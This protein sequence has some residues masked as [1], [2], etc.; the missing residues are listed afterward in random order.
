MVPVAPAHNLAATAPCTI[1]T[2]RRTVRHLAPRAR[3]YA[4][5]AAASTPT[6]LATL[7]LVQP[8]SPSHFCIAA[9]RRPSKLA[10]H[11]FRASIK[12]HRINISIHIIFRNSPSC[13]SSFR[14]CIN[15]TGLCCADFLPVSFFSRCRRQIQSSD[16]TAN[17]DTDR[18]RPDQTRFRLEITLKATQ[19]AAGISG[20]HH[21]SRG[22]NPPLRIRPGY[23]RVVL[24]G[25]AQPSP[26]RTHRLLQLACCGPPLL[27]S[28]SRA[29]RE[30]QRA[31]DNGPEAQSQ[32]ARPSAPPFSVVICANF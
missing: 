20:Y 15:P 2:T 31:S 6:R 27:L 5:I 10:C 1:T 14:P 32:R 28:P 18:T 3:S 17:S 24:L 7:A 4:C 30:K 23:Q 25:T 19:K 8:H 21:P 22:Q 9:F 26:G 13:A 11:R 29:G 12:A 16:R